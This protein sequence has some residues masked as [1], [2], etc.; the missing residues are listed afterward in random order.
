MQRSS[1][2]ELSVLKVKLKEM[3]D[4]HQ[5][6]LLSQPFAV[7]EELRVGS[8]S[9]KAS[10]QNLNSEDGFRGRQMILSG[11]LPRTEQPERSPEDFYA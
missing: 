10:S 7:Q 4:K 1:S 11:D 8:D 3:R 5:A 2:S 6:E 9:H